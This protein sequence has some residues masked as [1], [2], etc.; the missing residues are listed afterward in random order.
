MKVYAFEYTHCIFD[1]AFWT[2]SVHR[3]KAGAYKAM[4]KHKN[5]CWYADR[6]MAF[7]DAESVAQIGWMERWQ[8][9]EWEVQ[10]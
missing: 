10:C 8:I 9:R 4:M 3:T 6:K 5:D 2:V 7:R 1:S